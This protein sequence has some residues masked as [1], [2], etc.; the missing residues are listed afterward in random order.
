MSSEAGKKSRFRE[1]EVEL[2]SNTL[3]PTHLQGKERLGMLAPTPSW[4]QPWRVEPRSTC[5]PLTVVTSVSEVGIWG[6][7]EFAFL[8]SSEMVFQIYLGLHGHLT[9]ISAT[10]QGKEATDVLNPQARQSP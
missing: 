2:D 10:S 8:T 4:V 9:E 3:L 1:E 6:G 7:G 5:S